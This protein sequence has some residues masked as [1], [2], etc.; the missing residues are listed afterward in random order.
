[1]KKVISLMVLLAVSQSAF[2]Y[3]DGGKIASAKLCLS[4]A[5]IQPVVKDDMTVNVKSA[6]VTVSGDILNYN[7]P[8]VTIRGES[9]TANVILD[10]ECNLVKIKYQ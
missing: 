1:M 2:S 9:K 7:F 8:V 4:Q 5:L 6:G 3:D 10:K